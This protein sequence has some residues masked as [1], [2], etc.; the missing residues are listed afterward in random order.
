MWLSEIILKKLQFHRGEKQAIPRREL[1]DYLHQVADPEL[2]DRWMRRTYENLPICASQ[3][4]LFIPVSRAEVEAYEKYLSKKIAP[5]KVREKIIRLRE[6]YPE[7]WQ[8]QQL[9]L[10]I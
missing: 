1:L 6:A 2:S 10:G 5:W 9:E 8:V 4:G 7:L 3:Y